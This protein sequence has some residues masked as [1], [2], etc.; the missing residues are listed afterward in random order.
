VQACRGFGTHTQ[1]GQATPP[2]RSPLAAISSSTLFHFTDTRDNLLNILTVEFRPR[3]CLEDFSILSDRLRRAQNLQVA[4]PMVSFCDIPL[5]QVSKHME[6]YGCY[7]LGL[8]KKWAMLNGLSPVLYTHHNA[9][10]ARALY[11]LAQLARQSGPAPPNGVMSHLVKILFLSKP[12][13]GRVSR[14]GAR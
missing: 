8:S 5:S 9:T 14:R 3:F 10:T 13:E 6:T 2:A 12:Y 7:A 11:D 1:T 4:V